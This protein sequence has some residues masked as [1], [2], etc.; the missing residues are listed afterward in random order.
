MQSS[1]N[2]VLIDVLCRDGKVRPARVPN[3]DINREVFVEIDGIAYVGE[4][5]PI[6]T[7][8]DGS[9]NPRAFIEGPFEFFTEKDVDAL[10]GEVE[11]EYEAMSDEQKKQIA[12]SSLRVIKDFEEARGE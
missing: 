2:V 7:H 4:L 11:A 5:L 9:Y 10:E 3:G 12:D 8:E 1:S 6:S